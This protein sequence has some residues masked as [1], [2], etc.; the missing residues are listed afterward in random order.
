MKEHDVN[1]KIYDEGQLASIFCVVPPLL[2]CS[3]ICLQS[4]A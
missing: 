4:Q 1:T 3:P 2:R